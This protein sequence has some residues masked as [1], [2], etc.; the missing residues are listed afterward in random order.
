M[1]E[2]IG[3]PMPTEPTSTVPPAPK[4]DF[5]ASTPSEIHYEG[6]QPLI[7]PPQP[8]LRIADKDIAHEVALIEDRGVTL[9][10]ARENE[11]R[12]KHE[13]K[14][15]PY[16]EN[17]I[18]FMEGLLKVYPHALTEVV[19]SRGRRV[20]ILDAFQL[21]YDYPN[22]IL[23]QNGVA[24]IWQPGSAI[25]NLTNL[26]LTPVIDAMA[27]R[28]SANFR[29]SFSIDTIAKTSQGQH[30]TYIQY[31]ESDLIDDSYMGG[32]K[33]ALGNM[34]KIRTDVALVQAANNAKLQAS[35]LI[36]R[37]KPTPT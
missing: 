13:G 29:R 6:D 8:T 35:N 3:P 2:P 18:E 34:E 28:S 19:D 23:S 10:R 25:Y 26:D 33:N 27:D 24:T 16:Q 11:L 22:T 20:L 32:L 21:N 37:L 30:T 5:Y 36:E 15:T 7:T 17:N 14:L 9:A 31:Q 12:L 1:L 4:P